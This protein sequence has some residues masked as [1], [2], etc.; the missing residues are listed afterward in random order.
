MKN[1]IGDYQIGDSFE[2]F[3]L[4]KESVKG[5]TTNGKP[6][7]TLM[8]RDATGE[9]EAKL[10]DVTKEDETLFCQEQIIRITGEVNQFRGKAQMRINSIR[11]A[12]EMDGVQLS[13]FIEKAPVEQD[14]LIATL[15]ETIFEMTNPTIQRIVRAIVKKYQEPLLIYPAASR[16]HHEY[17]SGLLHHIVSMLK[18]ARELCELYPQVNKDLLYAGI[19]LH[20][21]GKMKELSGVI[22]TSY[23]LEGKLLGHI[24][25]MIEEIGHVAKELNVDGEEVLILQHLVLSHHG[26]AEWG[27]PTPPLVREAELLHLID[28]I[29]AKMNMLNRALDKV[30]PGEFTERLF[31]LDNRTFYKPTFE[32]S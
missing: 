6:F 17:V 13:D 27:S 15:T 32:N 29:D 9:I 12:H 5:T 26:K 7:L 1:G 30:K 22:S 23:T 21:I 31:P 28:L 11:L 19:I 18:I 16:N 2:G 20:D 3:V 24:P 14:E 25:I 4:I 10:W 8:L